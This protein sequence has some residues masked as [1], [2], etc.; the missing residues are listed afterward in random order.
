MLIIF[1]LLPVFY[2]NALRLFIPATEP[3]AEPHSGEVPLLMA[4][5]PIFTIIS[6]FISYNVKGLRRFLRR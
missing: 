4:G 1:T 6:G 3:S 2:H 5:H